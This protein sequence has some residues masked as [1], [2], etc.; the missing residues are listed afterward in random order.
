[1]A[2]IRT[3][4]PDAF[5]SDSLSRVPREARW[6]FAGLWTYCDDEGRG[7]YDVR[8]IKAALYPLDDDVTLEVLSGELDELERVGCICRYSIAGKRYLHV[9][10]WG[11]QKINRPTKSKLPACPED[12][13]EG[14]QDDS[15]TDHGGLTEGSLGERKGKE[16]GKGSGTAQL[17]VSDLDSNEHFVAFWAAYPRRTDKGHARTAWIK[18]LK[19]GHE[20]TEVIAAAKHYAARVVDKD[21]TY[22]PHPATWLNGERWADEEPKQPAVRLLPDARDLEQ[23]PDGLTP[24]EYAEW[25]A[26]RR[27]RQNA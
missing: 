24:A 9:P 21:P 26:D 20:P 18:M 27:A 1:M 2:R 13:H 4:K 7:R 10:A 16:Q 8:L 5:A 19:A 12:D 3:I 15:P 25:D 6:T 23:P 14:S 22:I 17:R 11:H